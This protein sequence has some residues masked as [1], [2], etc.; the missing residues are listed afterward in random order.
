MTR[1]A[2]VFLVVVS[3]GHGRTQVDLNRQVRNS[4][5]YAQGGTNA[6]SQVDARRNVGTPHLVATDFAGADIGEKVNN[7]FAS[8]PLS[9]CGAVQVPP[10]RYTYQTQIVMRGSCILEG[11][12]KGVELGGSYATEL[13]YNGPPAT[14][15]ITFNHNSYASVR[16]LAISSNATPCLSNG[17]LSWNPDAAGSNKWQCMTYGAK[18]TVT[19]AANASPIQIT[20]SAPHGLSTGDAVYITYV[21]GNWTANGRWLITVTG[22]STF[23]LNGS[24]GTAA[25]TSGG[26]VER[27]TYGAATPHLAAIQLG[28]V[29]PTSISTGTFNSVSNVMI[30]SSI[31]AYAFQ[32]G[33]FY[34]G[35]EHSLIEDVYSVQNSVGAWFNSFSQPVAIIRS[36]FRV[37][38][39]AGLWITGRSVVSCLSCLSENNGWILNGPPPRPADLTHYGA[40]IRFGSLFPGGNTGGPSGS[41]W[42]LD[43]YYFEGNDIDIFGPYEEP[44]LGVHIRKAGSPGGFSSS[45]SDRGNFNGTIMGCGAPLDPSFVQVVS[46]LAVT[47]DCI[48]FTPP[49]LAPPFAGIGSQMKLVVVDGL[50][51]SVQKIYVPDAMTGTPTAG[52]ELNYPSSGGVNPS[53]I[54]RSTGGVVGTTAALQLQPFLGAA[55]ALRTDLDSSAQTFMARRWNGAASVDSLWSFAATTKNPGGGSAN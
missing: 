13:I 53:Q 45:T 30:E 15:A 28:S 26:T 36:S 25:Y 33:L 50:V 24:A 19:G 48:G 55:T 6:S 21:R 38:R 40:G 44:V 43:N 47:P 35:Q 12:G 20:T 22:A 31:T 49:G 9:T 39:E 46:G 10:G 11:V 18:L 16:N 5:P 17:I 37:N 2:F 14:S 51:G 8:F 34:N 54:L 23:T 4:L 52:Y 29:D 1:G 32:F 27:L 42:A 3:L 7:A 41:F